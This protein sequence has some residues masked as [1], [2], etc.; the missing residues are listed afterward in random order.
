MRSMHAKQ[1][2]D[3]TR[4]GIA[5]PP[6]HTLDISAVAKR[7]SVDVATGLDPSQVAQRLKDTG[8]NELAAQQTTALGSMV[9]SQFKDVMILILIAAAGISGVVGEPL[10]A[11]AILVIVVLNAVVGVVQEYRAER[12][13]EALRSLAVPTARVRRAGAAS[14]VRAQELVPGD[15]VLLEAGNGVPADVRLIDAQQLSADEAALTG[16]SA[17]VEKQ[18]EPESEVELPIGDRTNLAFKG[19][20]ITRGRGVGVVIATGSRTELGHVAELL[21]GSSAGKTPLQ[22]RLARFGR[23]LAIAVLMICMTL[24]VTGWLRGEPGMLMFLTAVSLAVAAIPEALPAVITASL[25]VGARKISRAHALVRR[26]PAVETLGSVTYICSDKTGT[27]TENRMRVDFICVDGARFQALSEVNDLRSSLGLALALSN[28][29]ETD[30][31]NQTSGDPTEVALLEFA[32]DGGFAKQTLEASH[33]RIREVPFDSST[34]RMI[35]VHDS[36]DGPVAFLKGAPEAVIE[37]C[38]RSLGSDT[39]FSAGSTLDQATK[40]AHEGYRVLAIAEKRLND[41]NDPLDSQF[42]LT[43]LIALFD[44]PREG[45]SEAVKVC[46]RAGITPVMITGDHPGTALAIAA[47]VGIANSEDCVVTGQDIESMPAEELL[48]KMENA[49]VFARVDPAQKIRVVRALQAR[50]EYV[51]MTGDGVNDAPALKRADIGI[52]MGRKGTDVARESAEMVL[53]DDNFATI[54]AAVRE[55]R[56]IF[57]NILKFIKYTMTSN[58]GEIW[59]MFLAPLFGLPIPL[60]PIHILWINLVTDGLPGL[61]LAAEPG[62]RDLMSR[63][64]RPPTQSILAFGMWQHIVWVGLLI[65]I[66]SIASQAWAIDRGSGNWQTVVFTVLTFSQLAQVLAIRSDRQSVFSSGFLGNPFLLGAIGLTVILQ[67]AV[68][69]LPPLQRVFNTAPLSA[70]EFLAC[71]LLPLIVLVA[72]ELE[73]R[74]RLSR[75]I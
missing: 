20:L 61:A 58:S 72:V 59:T 47:R 30:G 17:T 13:L 70:V 69:Y 23:R 43:G 16:E 46:L 66:L 64:P 39:V 27:L 21:Q 52:A 25:A 26:L 10:D 68:V 32:R 38:A 75:R 22:K 44:P 73:K 57:D 63:P 51:A 1:T 18:V 2:P 12:A 71:L 35:T 11:A 60:L 36:P 65:G 3:E 29:A 45:V 28:D 62:E 54:V 48:E 74:L 8:P 24:F 42:T 7:L 9:L 4:T 5:H 55:G 33:P 49:R 67:L 53:M 14:V 41:R 50:G 40:L 6:W 56:R 34:K 15:I 37:L 19:T 31:D